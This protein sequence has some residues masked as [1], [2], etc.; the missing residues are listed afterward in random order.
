MTYHAGTL[1]DPA[2]LFAGPDLQPHQMC[3][4]ASA[5]R[6]FDR[7]A[8]PKP[9]RCGARGRRRI[10]A[11]NLRNRRKEGWVS[12]WGIRLVQHLLGRRAQAVTDRCREA[13]S[14]V[15]PRPIPILCCGRERPRLR[16]EGS[17]EP[18]PGEERYR[19]KGVLAEISCGTWS[20][21]A[22]IERAWSIFA[23]G[24][25]CQEPVRSC[26]TGTAESLSRFNSCWACIP[27]DDGTR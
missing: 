19:G 20:R 15:D 7:T 16:S 3:G 25:T 2:P 12:P 6:V 17:F 4:Y 13:H 1:I 18:S 9:T 22:A 23:P 11:P 14:E 8:R 10:P 5:D 21:P 26:V 24:M 27:A